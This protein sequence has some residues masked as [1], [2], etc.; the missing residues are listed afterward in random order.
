MP[1]RRAADRLRQRLR[2]RR[3]GAEE[4]VEKGNE[5]DRRR[6]EEVDHRS[7]RSLGSDL[8]RTWRFLLSSPRPQMDGSNGGYRC[9]RD[10][11]PSRKK[12][13]SRNRQEVKRRSETAGGA[14]SNCRCNKCKCTTAPL[15]GE[16]HRCGLSSIPLPPTAPPSI[17]ND[18]GPRHRARGLQPG[19]VIREAYKLHLYSSCEV[20]Y[21]VSTDSIQ[22]RSCRP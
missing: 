8:Y 20:Q 1:R 11:L 5:E 14:G 16:H 9:K 10:H 19:C 3:R 13:K 6:A 15:T 2:Q 18:S 12:E 21:F 22:A 7:G 4:E 17:T